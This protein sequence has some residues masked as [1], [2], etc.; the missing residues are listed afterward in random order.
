MPATRKNA[1]NILPLIASRLEGIFS[2]A[3]FVCIPAES[4]AAVRLQKP[5][6]YTYNI[7]RSSFISSPKKGRFP[8]L[9]S[10]LR[11]VVVLFR[12]ASNSHAKFSRRLSFPPTI[13]A[14]YRGSF[15]TGEK[16]NYDIRRGYKDCKRHFSRIYDGKNSYENY[17]TSL[18]RGFKL[19]SH[20]RPFPK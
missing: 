8:H 11:T 12:I 19:S 16:K 9:H 14:V 4:A 18:R 13:D 17:L 5:T 2:A 7:N 20:F 10:I 1:P 6:I 15:F 3:V